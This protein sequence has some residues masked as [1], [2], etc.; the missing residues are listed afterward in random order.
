MS[1]VQIIKNPFE[2]SKTNLFHVKDGT[3]V[4]DIDGYDKIN[5]VVY[6]NG[7]NVDEN[8]VLN[9]DDCCVIRQYPSA[10]STTVVTVLA[11]TAITATSVLIADSAVK[12]FSPAHKGIFER[13][14]DKYLPKTDSLDNKNPQQITNLP[15]ISGS[16]NQSALGK[17]IPLIL[18]R[19]LFTP[20]WLCTAYNTIGGV[21]GE[22]QYYNCLYLIGYKDIQ[23]ENVSIGLEVL[24][25][26]SNNVR[27]GALTITST[28]YPYTDQSHPEK[29]HYTQLELQC[30]Q[31]E[32]SLIPYK[33]VQENKNIQLK[34]VEGQGEYVYVNSVRYAK[35]VEIEFTF[36]GLV[37]YDTDGTPKD[38][39]QVK[40][41]IEYSLDGG[42]TWNYGGGDPQNSYVDFSNATGNN[43]YNSSTHEVYFSNNKTKTLRYV[44]KQ[45]LFYEQMSDCYAQTVMYRI[46]RTN[47]ES[48]DTSVIDKIYVTAIRT[49]CYDPIASRDTENLI[50]ERPMIEKYRDLTARLGFRIMVTEDLVDNFD[51]IN[52]IAT[53]LG[54]TWDGTGWSKE[55]SPTRN[56]ASLA[57]MAMT[58]DFR[59]DYAYNLT[60]GEDYMESDKIDLD[61]FGACYEL[62][63]EDKTFDVNYPSVNKK[64]LCDGAVVNSTKSIDLVNQILSTARSY[65]VLNGKKYGVFSDKP[66][67][68]PLLVLNNNNLLSLIY[69]RSFDEIPDGHSVKY[70]SAINYYQQ[71]TIVVKP[72]G[73]GD[74]TGSDKL[75]KVEYPYI[76][77][78]YH[79]CAMSRYQQACLA[80]RPEVLQA[81]VT[82]EGGLAEIG[83][84]I[85][86]QS[87]VILVGIGDG[88][89]VTE[90]IIEDFEIVGIKTDGR[91][92]V[93]DITKDY[94]VVINIVDSNGYEKT[95]KRKL[96]AF[97]STG[98]YTDLYFETS[99]D[100]NCGVE[101]GCVLSFGIHNYETVE[102]ICI[103]KKENGDGTY[104]LTLIPYDEQIYSA[105]SQ[106]FTDYA[107]KTTAPQESGLP[108]NYGDRTVPV[109]KQ[110]LFETIDNI[111]FPA[112]YTCS[113]SMSG[114]GSAVIGNV[115]KN[116]ELSDETLYYADFYGTQGEPA[117][118]T[119]DTGTITNGSF[120][121]SA[122]SG[123]DKH[124]VKIFSDSARTD[125]LCTAFV[126]FG[127]TGSGSTSYWLISDVSSV[128]RD[129]NGNFTPSAINLTAKMQT[130][131]SAP[132]NYTGV[133]GIAVSTNGSTYGTESYYSGATKSYTIPANTKLIRCRLYMTG[134]HTVLLDE[135]IITVVGGYQDYQFAV[136]AFDLT[137]EQAR[138]LSW[139]DAPP[140][141]T[142]EAPCLYMATKW[143]GA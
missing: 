87:D 37:K 83:S 55:L 97:E 108:I 36:G 136:G 7:K 35:T 117:T 49:W 94:G 27:N 65:L 88:A 18:G 102:E 98:E 59:G 110:E 64:Y 131:T 14:I 29:N 93:T 10:V 92:T 5:S 70:V 132:Q 72:Y 74:V 13:I 73:T 9:E 42:Q 66:Q 140:P 20:Y 62:C 115:Y 113:L 100:A 89:E 34:N 54:R 40:I 6:V 69:T 28:K 123:A 78:P 32:V 2:K 127:A 134:G 47:A 118:T 12:V 124:I 56:P 8:Y 129:K 75:Q 95:L 114:I 60:E 138:A 52:L 48:T 21:D 126:S 15:S 25:T 84:L 23:V 106:P 79:A 142:S 85:S 133:I 104:E 33:V 112:E 71:D 82:G 11:I 111:D 105:D 130:G 86:I 116:G 51:K 58:G 4:K 103:E 45:E 31:N 91:F 135:D 90:L 128:G 137:D 1:F 121:I 50:Y 139:Y 107:P 63:D 43:G 57:L 46:Q 96:Q 53:S 67:D 68:Y 16:K 143:I 119:G 44:Y 39:E 3:T 30:G 61:S 81:K 120:T 19:T 125:L 99:L 24:A 77:D 141:T 76:T 26:N 101:A 80:L 109:T 22:N 122:V 41:T 38:T 17:A